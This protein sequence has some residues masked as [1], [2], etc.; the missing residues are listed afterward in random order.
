MKRSKYIIVLIIIVSI[1]NIKSVNAKTIDNSITLSQPIITHIS[2]NTSFLLEE[3]S[4]EDLITPEL[5]KQI[6]RILTYVRIIVPILVIVLGMTDFARA[7]LAGKEE[8]MKKAQ[9]TFFYR[10]IIAAAIFLVP[11]IIEL[12]LD[13]ANMGWKNGLFGNS[14]CGIN[15]N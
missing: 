9:T 1:F 5:K 3:A 13:L 14:N 8:E 7:M 6:K 10:L 11:S 12:L 4:C 15:I 2:N